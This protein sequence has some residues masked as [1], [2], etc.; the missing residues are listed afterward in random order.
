MRLAMAR[1][2]AMFSSPI[3]TTRFVPKR[4]A[5]R[6]ANGAVIPAPTANGMV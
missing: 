2:M 6:A 3:A 5:A 1:P 4:K